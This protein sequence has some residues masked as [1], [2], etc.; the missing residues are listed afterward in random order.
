MV[1][2]GLRPMPL[3]STEVDWDQTSGPVG[4]VVSKMITIDNQPL[5]SLYSGGLYNYANETWVQTGI[6]HGLPENRAFDLEVDPR[7]H[8]RIYAG[9]MIAC[10][11]TSTDGGVSW[12]GW[13]D[14]MIAD[15]GGN[16]YS[17]DAM[18]LDSS[19]PDIIYAAGRDEFTVGQ[20]FRSTNQGE[21]W[22]IIAT[23][24][25]VP[26]FND[27]VSFDDRFYLATRSN[28]VYVSDDSGVTW[29]EF[30]TGLAESEI[31][32]FAIDPDANVLY[33]AT[34]LYQFNGRAGGQLYTLASSASEWAA[35][36][37]PANVTGLEWH[38]GRLW[39][40]TSTGEV[41]R[42][43]TN[44][45]LQLRNAENLFLTSVNEFSFSNDTVFV[46]LGG[47]GIY[48][49]TD[50]G[51]TFTAS[52]TGLKSMAMRQVAVNPTQPSQYYGITWDRL[53]LYYTKNSGASYRLLAPDQYF[54]VMTADPQNFKHV[55]AAGGNFYDITVKKNTAT[56]TILDEP[57]P[58]DDVIT[59]LAVHPNNGDIVLAGLSEAVESI[60]GHGVYRS[61][62]GGRNWTHAKG[63]PNVGVHSIIFNPDHPK[64]VYAAAFGRG[65]YKS[66]NGGKSWSK[67]I[68]GDQL[69]YVYRLAM[70]PSDP[71]TLLAGSQLFFAGLSTADQISGE[72]G[73]VFKTTNGGETWSE[74]TASLR[75]YDGTG[76]T[77]FFG[78]KYNFGHLPNYEEMLIDPN[79]PNV[80]LIG[81]HGENVVMTTDNGA[82]W[83]KPVDGMIPN[84]LH[85][86]AYCLGA[87]QDFS[88]IYACTCGRG[89]FK[90]T[91]D[92]ET[93][94][95]AW[96]GAGVAEPQATDASQPITVS[97]ARARLLSG[98]DA[99]DHLPLQLHTHD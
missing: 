58:R 23:F 45:T 56:T 62:N 40:G 73:G 99:H 90:G 16:N 21:N 43:N 42:T 41:W 49:S 82:T 55:Y 8:D 69:K 97:A 74:I 77:E 15:L 38:D 64:T 48:R 65:V 22:E 81:H 66:T 76:D 70:D 87:N 46:G 83:S 52:N 95:L 2:V 34:G 6:G 13:C 24:A 26:Y 1:L 89:M 80:M 36:A 98:I 93:L 84:S 88:K 75:D 3:Y 7:D 51:K 28:G 60:D 72:Y 17:V 94:T 59:A 4:G 47:Y 12:D 85:N 32:R 61:I 71:D 18:L 54:L 19:N 39:A 30:N 10:G 31:T 29:T 96:E 78:W 35:L 53:G 44:G 50:N 33:V 5:A 27:F 25:D 57:G 92:A 14:N 86:Y 68:G 63:L 79:N 20:I 11:A 37:E 9:L 67:L 91:F